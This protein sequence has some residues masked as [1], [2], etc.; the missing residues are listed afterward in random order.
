MQAIKTKPSFLALIRARIKWPNVD[1]AIALLPL[2]IW[3]TLLFGTQVLLI[4]IIS[5]ATALLVEMLLSLIFKMPSVNNLSSALVLA[6]LVVCLLPPNPPL[7]IPAAT[8]GIASLI[9]IIVNRM[10]NLGIVSPTIASIMIMTLAFPTEMTVLN[11]Q[12]VPALTPLGYLSLEI[13]PEITT[14]TLVF[15]LHYGFIG[16]I[17]IFLIGLSLIY[18]LVRKVI[19]W[20]IPATFIGAAVLF[21]YALPH[22]ELNPHL[23][24][25]A[26]IL[27][28]TLIFG[29]VF[30]ATDYSITPKHP[31][32]K[33]AF[34]LIAGFS[35]MLIRRY[36]SIEEG[37]LITLLILGLLTPIFDYI[38]K[39][40]QFAK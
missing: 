32:G 11:A 13:L 4:T 15:G 25:P 37:V 24:L 35:T 27:S 10:F 1:Y 34:G 12:G 36:T 19:T 33:L 2:I 21:A 16:E 38:F 29:A 8:V 22:P 28:G 39:P 20:H 26:A 14:E 30:L 7:W 5:I 23:Y 9:K 17:S 3:A 40:K 6:L 18:L 31:I